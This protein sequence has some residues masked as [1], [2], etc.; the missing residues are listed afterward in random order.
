MFRKNGQNLTKFCICIHIDKIKVGIATCN[1]SHIC[2]RVMT[3]DLKHTP[4]HWG[5]V[6]RSDVEI[7]QINIFL[8]N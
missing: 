7:L 5:Q 6:E 2:S 3:L 4:D 1:F 8:L